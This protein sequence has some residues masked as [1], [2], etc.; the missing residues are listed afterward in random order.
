MDFSNPW[1][2]FSGMAI[3]MIGLALFIHGKKA[4]NFRN[5]GIGL[6]MMIY[7]IFIH[8]V[9]VLWVIAGACMAG[10][11]FLPDGS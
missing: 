6:G 10:A 1:L 8:S 3:S 7:P 5:L 4:E 2:L 11:Y 9:L